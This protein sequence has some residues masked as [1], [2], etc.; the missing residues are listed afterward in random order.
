[1]GAA[2]AQPYVHQDASREDDPTA[3]LD[4]A[5]DEMRA[6]IAA[7]ETQV[8]ALEAETARLRQ[9]LR[10]LVERLRLRADGRPQVDSPPVD[11]PVDPPVA[12]PT[13]DWPAAPLV[14]LL[15]D[16]RDDSPV[17]VTVR[18]G[19]WEARP[20][21][22]FS[23]V[24]NT[25][26]D[27]QFVVWFEQIA[28]IDA[29]RVTVA[30][31]NGLEGVGPAYFEQYSIEVGDKVV[32]DITGRHVIPPRYALFR[33]ASVGAEAETLTN[34]TWLPSDPDLPAWAPD[35]AR[36][37]TENR[38]SFP[39]RDHGGNPVE[40]GPYNFFWANRSL[41]DSHG[42][43]GV[44]P[45]HGG[46]DDWLICPE[47]YRNREA[48]MLL[49][50][51]R[52]I[53]FLDA[54]YEPFTPIAPYWMGRTDAHEPPGYR[55]E[56]DDWCSYASTLVRYK[57]PEASHLSRGPA[58]AAAVAPYDIVG[59][60]CLEMVFTDFKTAHSLDPEHPGALQGNFLLAPLVTKIART[61]GPGNGGDRTLA[62]KLR[63]LRWCRPYFD[64][65]SYDAAM[66][67]WV[68][69][70]SDRYGVQN[71]GAT[72][73]ALNPSVLTEPL[74][75]P[76][77]YTFH[78]QLNTYEIGQFGGLDDIYE[79]GVRFLTARP[80]SAF[81]LRDGGD[82]DTVLLRRHSATAA[83]ADPKWSYTAYGHMTHGVLLTHDTPAAF[84]QNMA[85]RGVNGSS[86]DLDC[87][88]KSVWAPE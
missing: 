43:W 58:G 11:P 62:H 83:Q 85:G 67:T 34:W 70:L 68:R 33:R 55:Y 59:E 20:N 69:R 47:G 72:P 76:T 25:I 9:E 12:T 17:T 63:L 56:V 44:A 54:N 39:F 45:F 1:M 22:R 49:A 28:D 7:L 3:T 65:A 46:P 26:A 2:P 73:W 30:A 60:A 53:W 77:C 64:T 78:Q 10:L 31:I 57:F 37:D 23:K 81:E 52:G 84:L 74:E 79:A 21:R 41:G 35:A 50:F 15:Y 18:P 87:T 36:K 16:S 42:G 61:S 48:E 19:E 14:T 82:A 86:Q 4:A 6:H 75:A 40:L 27:T 32:D 29:T 24:G 80:P 51:Q 66:R 13:G 71:S 38:T 88:P 8:S 5:I